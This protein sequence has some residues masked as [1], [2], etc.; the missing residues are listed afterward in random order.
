MQYFYRLLFALLFVPLLAIAAK[1][2]EGLQDLPEPPPAPA[3]Y[4]PD[5]ADD[6]QPDIVIKK[7]GEDT[8]EEYSVHGQVYMVKVTPPTGISYYLVKKTI[9]GGWSRMDGPGDHIAI[10]HWVIFTF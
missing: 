6:T 3:G 9:D 4:Q 1:V 10:P 5:Q 7:K 2:P 8:I